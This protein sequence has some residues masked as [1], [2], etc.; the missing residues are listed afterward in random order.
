MPPFL[1]RPL[2]LRRVASDSLAYIEV[3]HRLREWVRELCQLDFLE[4]VNAQLEQVAPSF[5]ELLSRYSPATQQSRTAFTH[6]IEVGR[7]TYYAWTPLACEAVSTK[8]EIRALL[9]RTKRSLL[10]RMANQALF[11]FLAEVLFAAVTSKWASGEVSLSN[12][13]DEDGAGGR[14]EMWLPAEAE[15]SA[16][17]LQCEGNSTAAL[18]SA[19]EPIDGGLI[20]AQCTFRAVAQETS[21][22][23]LELAR[24]A[25]VILVDLDHHKYTQHI[26][27]CHVPPELLQPVASPRLLSA[28]HEL[29]IRQQHVA[30]PD[31]LGWLL[32][33]G[34][35]LPVRL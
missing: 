32:K 31:K 34:Y 3:V 24:F 1:P 4:R 9:L 26:A 8:E 28:S 35:W 22:E 18:G 29:G 33:R 19:Q 16:S 21:G 20:I 30:Q 14:F 6:D 5:E 27:S 10:W 12:V 2:K 7:L 15:E 23:E 25:C 11:E 17:E 13:K